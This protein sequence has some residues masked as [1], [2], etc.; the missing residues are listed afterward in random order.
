MTKATARASKANHRQVTKSKPAKESTPLQRAFGSYCQ[1]GAREQA[2]RILA[3]GVD[4][5]DQERK[6]LALRTEFLQLQA[7]RGPLAM[8]HAPL[9]IAFNAIG[10]LSGFEAA[11]AWGN[12]SGFNALD[13]EIA[14]L[15]ERAGGLVERM[16]SMLPKTRAG[17]AAV[18]TSIKEDQYHLWKEPDEDRDW[19]VAL[20]TRFIDG[21]VECSSTEART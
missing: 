4:D 12:E 5:A 16:I 6:I 19:D 10:K 11:N 7:K 8:R 1:P 18:A 15:D 13:R 20:V 9:A 2:L 14:D 3:Q 17:I 21:L